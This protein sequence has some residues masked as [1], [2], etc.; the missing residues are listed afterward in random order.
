MSIPECILQLKCRHIL[1]H[2]KKL[3]TTPNIKY[4]FLQIVNW[5][6]LECLHGKTGMLYNY[7]KLFG[8]TWFVKLCY[9]VIFPSFVL[10]DDLIVLA[11]AGLH[12]WSYIW[13][14]LSS[15][16]DISN[17]S[18]CNIGPIRSLCGWRFCSSDARDT[19]WG[20]IKEFLFLFY[21][22]VEVL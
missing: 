9:F 17:S 18:K 7:N 2:T 16:I 11:D 5:R 1:A 6:W 14:E 3:S 12:E 4:L 20:R 21:V 8:G 22:L 13:S 15:F 19:K 10:E